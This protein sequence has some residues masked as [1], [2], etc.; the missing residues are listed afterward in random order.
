MSLS[1]PIFS[2]I[3]VRTAVSPSSVASSD[4]AIE[5]RVSP[6]TPAVQVN[7]SNAGKAAS[8][9]SSRNADIEQSGLP[10]SVQK[11]LK[12]VRELQRRIEETMEKIQKVLSDKSLTYDERQTQATALQT[13]L[14]MLQRQVSNSTA[15]LSVLM[16]QLQSSDSDKIKAGI[17]V[18]AKM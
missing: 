1:G 5:T 2:G 7:L 6:G 16:N 8:S 10:E 14:G 17:L 4:N 18:M 12:A 15:D 9:A 3:T 11:I 13:V